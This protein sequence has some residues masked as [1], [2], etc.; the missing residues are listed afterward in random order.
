MR[1]I[2]I[3]IFGGI[4][5]NA[6]SEDIGQI[7]SVK[8]TNFSISKIGVLGPENL[9][10]IRTSIQNKNID[11]IHF[12]TDPLNNDQ[13]YVIVILDDGA[14]EIWNNTFTAPQYRGFSSSNSSLFY[15]FTANTV[16][17]S[18]MSPLVSTGTE[19]VITPGK[20]DWPIRVQ[21]IKDRKFFGYH[22]VVNNWYRETQNAISFTDDGF[23]V[24][25]ADARLNYAKDRRYKNGSVLDQNFSPTINSANVSKNHLSNV[26]ISNV[27]LVSSEQN[28][29]GNI[30]LTAD[31]SKGS[32]H[33]LSYDFALVYDG[34][35]ISPMSNNQ[36]ITE[37]PS[38]DQY[39]KRS[40]NKG[41]SVKLEIDLDY[42]TY[43]SSAVNEISWN[44][45][46]T[47]LA[48]YR[49]I[50]NLNYLNTS[51]NLS[52][53]AIGFFKLDRDS[54]SM[55]RVAISSSDVIL[56][57][58]DK[59]V[60]LDMQR[61]SSNVTNTGNY[62]NSGNQ[63]AQVFVTQSY[64]P[65]GTAEVQNTVISSIDDTTGII[66]FDLNSITHIMMDGIHSWEL[67][68][69]SD[70]TNNLANSGSRLIGGESWIIIPGLATD[71]D[72]YYDRCIITEQSIAEGHKKDCIVESFLYSRKDDSN[73]VRYYHACR[74]VGDSL[75][76]HLKT[77]GL[78]NVWIY[79]TN[80]PIHFD[81]I[82]KNDGTNDKDFI[83]CS[84]YDTRS[85]SF[86][87]HPFGD[88]KTNNTYNVVHRFN[89]RQWVGDVTID[90]EGEEE[91]FSNLIL[92]SELSQYSVIPSKNFIRITD[93][94]GGKIIGFSDLG[95]SLY[96]FLESS[97]YTLNLSS[98]DK[99]NW[100]LKKVSDQ[101][102]A[103][104]T[105]SILKL[106]DRIYF[107]G[108]ESIYYITATEQIVP[109]SSAI[110]NKYEKYTDDEKKKIHCV[111]DV[112]N[113]EIYVQ[114]GNGSRNILVLH[115]NRD[116]PTWTER[117]LGDTKDLVVSNHS[118]E[119][120]VISNAN[121]V[122]NPLVR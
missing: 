96:I 69:T 14:V 6:D 65:S 104:A 97:I 23:F 1:R 115:T 114:T 122:D 27:N 2:N 74:L 68:K 35:N 45:R 105:G 37:I 112:K 42:Q 73:V 9:F 20:T 110:N 100:V 50:S 120:T 85:Q 117:S 7:Q 3:D 5:T 98:G 15:S 79:R 21:Y 56:L 13:R 64:S 60:T 83:R 29:F 47:G 44:P 48:V 86:D 41:Y 24:D 94:D 67:R 92:F 90:K 53:R 59:A 25:R 49:N 82:N 57:G 121:R 30:S 103:I 58:A 39:Q 52:K 18:P 106:K 63:T 8:N 12:A 108:V 38:V 72:G 16:D 116:S 22:T 54:N 32:R 119:L 10:R 78:I 26:S 33:Q 111:Y 34:N 101:I 75:W 89:G 43:V 70:H 95:N 88:S 55:N 19:T 118:S 109:I 40:K 46:I 11:T 4:V 31:T 51:S 77:T 99:S 62:A 81:R 17:S 61:Q 71:G 36:V 80:E 76:L 102:G 107:A 113:A 84:V 66:T 91:S 87:A 28:Y 93:S